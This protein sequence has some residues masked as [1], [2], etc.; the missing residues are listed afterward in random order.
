ME[1][2]VEHRETPTTRPTMQRAEDLVD[3]LGQ[4]ATYWGQRGGMRLR[5]AA[6][7]LREDMED[8]WIEVK[9]VQSQFHEKPHTEIHEE[10]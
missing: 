2:E 10:C 9:T 4:R 3:H 5:R 1:P 7:H 6:A 8:M